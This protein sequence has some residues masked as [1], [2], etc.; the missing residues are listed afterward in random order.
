MLHLGQLTLTLDLIIKL[1]FTFA[2]THGFTNILSRSRKPNQSQP[3]HPGE[4]PIIFEHAD[5]PASYEKRLP[6]T[7]LCQNQRIIATVVGWR[8]DKDLY[9][10]CLESFANDQS[11]GPLIA[12]IDGDTA[13]DEDM[14]KIFLSVRLIS[15]ILPTTKMD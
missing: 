7:P 15:S 1:L 10:K 11:C 5:G 6:D 14:V 2:Y 4:Q 12:G 3:K 13:E 8:E 9:R